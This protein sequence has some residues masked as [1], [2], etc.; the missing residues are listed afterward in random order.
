MQDDHHEEMHMKNTSLSS[1]SKF[2]FSV[3]QLHEVHVKHDSGPIFP[4]AIACGSQI[5]PQSRQYEYAGSQSR[6][7]LHNLS[8]QFQASPR[9]ITA[10]IQ[11]SYAYPYK[12]KYK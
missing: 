6:D 3:L 12:Y 2:G 9:S 10:Q 4:A 7:D 11:V 8:P 1:I 5:S